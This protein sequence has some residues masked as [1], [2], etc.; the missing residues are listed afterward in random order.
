MLPSHRC[1][2][3]PSLDS[4]GT[5]GDGG[6]GDRVEMRFKMFLSVYNFFFSARLCH[7]A[8]MPFHCCTLFTKLLSNGV[9]GNMMGEMCVSFPEGM[10]F[11][12]FY[13]SIKNVARNILFRS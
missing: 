5:G 3:S 13:E 10:F 2:T 1:I 11:L 8:S 12:W 9:D 6:G 4:G 7:T